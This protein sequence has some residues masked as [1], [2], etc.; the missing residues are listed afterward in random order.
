MQ[1]NLF[2]LISKRALTVVTTMILL[3]TKC[4]SKSTKTINLSCKAQAPNKSNS[5]A[6]LNMSKTCW[7]SVT[8]SVLSLCSY[9][10]SNHSRHAVI[11]LRCPLHMLT[12]RYLLLWH[13]RTRLTGSTLYI[14]PSHHFAV[15]FNYLL[16]KHLLPPQICLA[17]CWCI[18]ISALWFYIKPLSLNWV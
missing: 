7:G 4:L 2:H 3:W 16:L 10:S 8:L 9:S 17:M 11:S 1:T 14:W 12:R 5:P 13:K 15:H 18:T 6:S